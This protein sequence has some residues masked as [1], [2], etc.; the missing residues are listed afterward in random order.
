MLLE[1]RADAGRNGQGLA[2][3]EIVVHHDGVACGAPLAVLP[4]FL[5]DGKEVLP[6]LATH[7]RI[8]MSAPNCIGS[9][10]ST[11]MCAMIRFQLSRRMSG[12]K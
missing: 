8:S 1:L 7:V 11:S 10:K 3:L 2:V 4:G 12:L 5:V 6:I 9:R